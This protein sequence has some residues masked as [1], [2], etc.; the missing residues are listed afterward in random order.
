MQ[1][2]AE[3]RADAGKAVAAD[4]EQ[5]EAAGEQQHYHHRHVAPYPRHHRLLDALHGD[6]VE[7]LVQRLHHDHLER[8]RTD[9]HDGAGQVQQDDPRIPGKHAR[10]P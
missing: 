7:V 5:H 3:A 4:V 6:D 10:W 9:E 2:V 8:H 1:P